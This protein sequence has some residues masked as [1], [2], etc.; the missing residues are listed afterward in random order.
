MCF[1]FNVSI[2]AVYGRCAFAQFIAK[3][4]KK[5]FTVGAEGVYVYNE[6]SIY[7]FVQKKSSS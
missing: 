2:F 1:I 7:T 5:A 3:K 4:L 6:G